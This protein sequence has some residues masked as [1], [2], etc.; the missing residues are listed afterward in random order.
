MKKSRLDMPT[1]EEPL[2]VPIFTGRK[3]VEY[4]IGVAI[5]A[6]ALIYFWQWWILDAVHIHLLGSILVSALLAWITVLPVYFITIFFNARK[7]AGPLRIPTGSRVAMVVTKASS[8]PF[9]VVAETLLAMLSQNVPHDTWL[10]DE[11][12]SPETFAWCRDHGVFV[13]TRKGRADYHRQSWP[14]RTRCKEGNLAFFYDHFGYAN[15]EFVSQ[16]DADHVPEP[17]YLFQM[18]RPFA[19]PAIGYVSAPSICDRNA[20]ESWSARGRLYVEAS[21]HGSLQAGYNGGFATVCIGSHYAVRTAALKEIGGLGPELAEDHSTTL[22][23]NAH[24]WR[25]AH[26]L[27]AIA[28]GDG[29][30][31]FAD[32]VT[33]EFQWSRSLVMILLQYTPKLIGRMPLHLK[34]QFV[35][36]QFWYPLYAFFLAMMFLLPVIVLAHG[37]NFVSV[38]Y[39][40]FLQHFMPQSLMILF[41]AFWWRASGTFRPADGKILSWEA[42]LFLLARWPWVLA[43]TFAASR[44]WLTGTFVDFRVT[45]KGAADVDA[46]PLRILAPYLFVVLISI[47]PV[48]LVRD[49]AET[50]GFYVF[51]IINA[52]FYILLLV[53]IV[54]QHARENT[55]RYRTRFYQPALAASLLALVTLPTLATAE[56][57]R[58]GIEALAWGTRSFTLFDDR[59]SVA[60][61][62]VGGRDTHKTIFSPRWREGDA[63]EQSLQ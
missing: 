23:M 45:P 18:L 47:L 3:R 60:G 22:F 1:R 38:T 35:F 5:W 50:R 39:P 19:D 48:L 53:M 25:G 42:M 36:S 52:C 29:P 24:G 14:R 43:G 10:A 61:A 26:A 17:D 2:M 15:Y 40:N 51:A 46:L 59:F 31:T 27:D 11:D 16:L 30:R 6:T 20:H 21:M 55:V 33:Q 28:H 34:V 62:G 57:G 9:H 8:E 4:V 49:D 56:R 44:D 13:S 32:L 54:V 63:G 58:D 12:P 41:L 37:D 7:P